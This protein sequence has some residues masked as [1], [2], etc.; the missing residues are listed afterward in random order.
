MAQKSSISTLDPAIRKA[1][2]EAVRLGRHTIDEITDLIKDLGGEVSRSA[3]GRYV[4]SAKDQMQRYAQAQE[5]AKMWVGKLEQEPDGDVGRL[6]TEMLRTVA[7]ST[8]ST[9]GDDDEGASAQEV[10]FL[11]KALK[12]LASADKI[13]A[14][15]AMAIKREVIKQA[16]E[17]AGETGA[18]EGL[19]AETVNRIKA[20]ILGISS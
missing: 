15:R 20:G 18:S 16:A 4:K 3:V 9:M 12:E 10:M 5:I 8:V 1:V 6:L 19:S 2:D 14:D 7:F 13:S 17:K 11:A